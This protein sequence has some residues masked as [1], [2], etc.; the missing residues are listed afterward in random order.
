LDSPLISVVIPVRND[1]DDLVDTI[2]SLIAGNTGGHS[3]EIVVVDDA[4]TI[5][6]DAASLPVPSAVRLQLI[7]SEERL[8]V[9]RARNR[10]AFA[11][12]GDI[13]FI[14]DSHIEFPTRW[15]DMVVADI[16]EDRLLAATIGAEGWRG[17]GC[18]LIV[19]FMGTRWNRRRP[20]HLAPVQIAS[21]A[22]TILTKSLF[23]R[24]GGYD[25]GMII[26]GAA[27]P[28]FSI[29]T[30]LAGATVE[31][32]PNLVLSHK[33]K[34][35]DQAKQFLNDSRATLTHNSL[36][37]GCLYLSEPAILQMMRYYSN[38]F[39]ER[40]G[41]ALNLLNASDVV[42]RREMLRTRL[43]HEFSW[44]ISRFDLKDQ[45]GLPIL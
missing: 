19:P 38:R 7:R 15:S 43:Q 4:S 32:L 29:R 45:V 33:F 40:I 41:E 3:L 20:R 36:R 27:E 42:P 39:P 9:P 10:G 11:A 37:F 44:F 35:R 22:G 8:G 18:R 16:R 28:E 17:Y 30:W 5:P 21:S 14:T 31:S 1:A 23:E 2:G 26:Y 6:I 13:L 25:E 24:L 12:A 34:P